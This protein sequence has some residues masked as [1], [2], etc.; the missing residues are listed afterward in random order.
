MADE[1]IFEKYLEKENEGWRHF[2]KNPK[3]WVY[4]VVGL[5]VIFLAGYFYKSVIVEGMSE[6]D[7]KKSIQVVWAETK[8]IEQKGDNMQFKIVPAILFKVKNVGDRPL[9]F[10]D[11]EAVFEFSEN[12]MV[13]EDGMLRA[14]KEPL[15]PGQT[16]ELLTIVPFHGYQARSKETFSKDNPLWKKMQAKLF[17]RSKGSP[18]AR[19]GGLYPISQVIDWKLSGNAETSPVAKEKLDE[20]SLDLIS[21]LQV[22][23]QDSMWISKPINDKQVTIVPSITVVIKN[24]GKN[25]QKN[26]YFKGVFR[27]EDTGEVLSE[28]IVQG[29]TEELKFGE[30]ADPVRIKAEFGYSASSEQSFI[31]ANSRL[32]FLKVN[33]YAKKKDTENV[34]LGTYSIQPKMQSSQPY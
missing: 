1:N 19:I 8:W 29:I 31:Q 22:V 20:K 16:S 15:N 9:E 24:V 33:V 32:K 17:A 30:T 12:G 6:S 27:Y 5:V 4:I 28:G 23:S 3:A 13:S 26:V 34:L 2:Y 10:M 25:P 14:F 11:F 21:S 18:L 7:I